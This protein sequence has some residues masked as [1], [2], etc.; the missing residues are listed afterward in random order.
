MVAAATAGAGGS[1]HNDAPAG[2]MP[3]QNWHYGARPL[4][5]MVE[6]GG[7]AGTRISL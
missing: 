4:W 5:V 2:G 7:R 3:S 6:V 1:F